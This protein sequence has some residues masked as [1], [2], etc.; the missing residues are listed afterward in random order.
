MSNQPS[1][2]LWSFVNPVRGVLVQR[3]KR[4]LADV[5]LESGQVVTAHCPNTGPM[6]GLITPGTPVIVSHHPR[7]TARLAYTWQMAYVQ[8]TWVGVNTQ[9]PN[10]LL[11]RVL[12]DPTCAPLWHRRVDDVYREVM[13]PKWQVPGD[14]TVFMAKQPALKTPKTRLDFLLQTPEGPLYTE[15]KNVHMKRAEAA[16]FPD[17]VTVR[18]TRHMQALIQVRRQG[19]GAALVYVVQRDDVNCLTLA[20]DIDPDYTQA[21]S[22][23]RRAGVY[24][25]ALR[26]S[27]HVQG[28]TDLQPIPIIYDNDKSAERWPLDL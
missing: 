6:T 12:G 11:A 19:Y 8:E 23:A 28:I 16:C 1:K 14:D 25:C 3:Y 18:G 24:A 21:F 13:L 2:M 17:A 10:L 20:T 15:V 5:A 9:V 7:P 26:C 4:F 22:Q 27:M